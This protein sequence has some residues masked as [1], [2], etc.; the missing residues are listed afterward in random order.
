MQVTAAATAA[1]G[2]FCDEMVKHIRHTAASEKSCDKIAK[3]A[4]LWAML[5]LCHMLILASYGHLVIQWEGW[6]RESWQ[7]VAGCGY[8]LTLLL[9]LCQ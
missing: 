8:I 4:R 9:G 2:E 7:G 3:H 1:P 6:C 5:C